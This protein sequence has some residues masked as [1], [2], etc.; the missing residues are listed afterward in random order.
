MKKIIFFLSTTLL[1]SYS[2]NEANQ[3]VKKKEYKK[4]LKEYFLI[5]KDGMIAKYNIGYMY[6]K[7]LGVK[8]DLKTAVEFYRMSANDGFAPAALLVGNAYLKGIGVKKNLR[9]A[10]YYYEIAAKGGN[11]EAIKILNE[12]KKQI[13]NKNKANLAYITVRSN[14]YNDKVY[15]DGKYVGH[16]KITLPLL[17]GIH[18]L[19]VKKEGYKPY[20]V[21]LNIKP[22]EKKTIKAVLEKR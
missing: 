2:L 14:V 15:I 22:K 11:K 6:E 13:I 4:A 20:V 19:E 9:E 12:I 18:I 17:P 1:F 8:K 7:G 3:L 5:A 21:K 10:I 16:T